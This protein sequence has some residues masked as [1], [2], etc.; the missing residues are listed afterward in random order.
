MLIEDMAA[1]AATLNRLRELG[2]RVAIDDFGTGYSSLR[3]LR[4]LPVDAI[5]LD[6]SFVHGLESSAGALAIVEGITA[7]AH[8]I[9]L[10]VT[11]EGIETEGQLAHLQAIGCDR[12]QGFLLGKPMPATAE[13]PGRSGPPVGA[14]TGARTTT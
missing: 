6:R 3:Y 9:G 7:L 10:A 1:T 2:V 12:G 4:E 8:A 13:P 14:R 11:A 5:K